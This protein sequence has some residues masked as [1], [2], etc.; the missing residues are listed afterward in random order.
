MMDIREIGESRKRSDKII[1]VGYF[2]SRC[3]DF[4]I[5]KM[6]R[7]PVALN[8]DSWNEAYDMFFDTLSGGRTQQQFRDTLRNTREI[9]DPLFNSRRKSWSGVQKNVAELS[10]RDRAVHQEWEDRNDEELAEYVL[11][12]TSITAKL[13]SDRGSNS[14]VCGT[15]INSMT[16]SFFPVYEVAPDPAEA[17]WVPPNDLPSEHEVQLVQSRD[18]IHRQALKGASYTARDIPAS[19]LDGT[20]KKIKTGEYRMH[21]DQITSTLEKLID[22]LEHEISD[23]NTKG[24]HLFGLSQYE[25]AMKSAELGRRLQTFRQKVVE[26]RSD[27]DRIPE[28]VPMLGETKKIEKKEILRD[29]PRKSPKK[30]LIAIM[31]DGRVISSK[32]AAETFAKTIIAMGIEQVE[33]LGLEVNREPLISD[34]P[35]ERYKTANIDGYYLMTHSSTSQKKN[36]LTRIA[37][38]LGVKLSVKISD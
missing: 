36:L 5:D 35:S 23:L 16:A 32:T 25:N 9:F 28:M 1:L 31:N 14:N 24:A 2:L 33:S 22:V 37:N 6:P 10:K 20:R 11:E 15:V 21:N 3:T 12:V 8:I 38:E 29:T 18:T 30:N 17:D 7:P 34:T 19:K 13:A 4:S 26:L 27:W